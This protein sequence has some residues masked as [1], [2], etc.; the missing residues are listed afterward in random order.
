MQ[1][2]LSN[3]SWLT[4]ASLILIEI[5]ARFATHLARGRLNEFPT[6]DVS[7][8]EKFV[9]YHPQLGWEPRP[10]S[11]PIADTGHTRRQSN[12]QSTKAKVTYKIDV[13]GSRHHPPT[14]GLLRGGPI[15]IFGDSTV[16]CR[17]NRDDETYSYYLQ[18]DHFLG[19]VKNFGVGNYGIDQAYLRA[20]LKMTGGGIAILDLALQSIYRNVTV[21]KHY[22]EIGNNWAVKPRFKINPCSGELQLLARPLRDRKELAELQDHASFLR[23]NDYFYN[24]FTANISQPGLSHSFY[25]ANNKHALYEFSRS[26]PQRH[27][28]ATA[29]KIARALGKK[30]Y[31][32]HKDPDTLLRIAEGEGGEIVARIIKQF[33]S[34]AKDRGSNPLVVMSPQGFL[35][36][37]PRHCYEISQ[38]IMRH[39][40]ELGAPLPRDF[41]SV[42]LD[43][44]ET[45]KARLGAYNVHMSPRGN[46][47]KAD[48]LANEIQRLPEI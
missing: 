16:F 45:E 35:L 17:G 46:R 43:K 37:H 8:L 48:W 44:A 13:D 41:G 7:A 9:N 11:V 15:E 14:T 28:K 6:V 31:R 22:A 19:P 24:S 4:M 5:F 40:S 25:L 18:H 38:Q 47:V 23:V 29:P 3:T 26:L 21:Y 10:T 36:K 39:C 1:V 20:Q 33:E 2:N 30:P 12:T 34:L 42:L 27:L 32:P